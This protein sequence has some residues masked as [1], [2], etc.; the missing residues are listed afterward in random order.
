MT[1]DDE[2]A[3]TSRTLIEASRRLLAHEDGQGALAPASAAGRVYAK[4]QA[5]LAPL[6]GAAGF[7]AVMARSSKLARSDFPFFEPPL[8]QS[9]HSLAEGLRPLAVTEG[10]EAAAALFATF[11]ALLA[12]LI[13]ERLTLHVLRSA[14][15]TLELGLKEKP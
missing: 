3:L 15:P 6:V 13:G 8:V 7:E 11:L 9:A 5:A 2:V 10:R 14:W 1:A 4:L 12:S